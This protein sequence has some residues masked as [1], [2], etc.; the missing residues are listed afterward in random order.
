MT[1]GLDKGAG[2]KSY[3]RVDELL[4]SRVVEGEEAAAG[5][6]PVQRCSRLCTRR[7]RPRQRAGAGD[8][9]AGRIR[10]AVEVDAREAV[11]RKP[12]VAWG[13]TVT[14][15]AFCGTYCYVAEGGSTNMCISRFAAAGA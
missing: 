14:S 5:G 10:V 8:R 7:T 4:S 15:S 3:A 12:K 11:R 13:F 2:A 1:A 6:R 9:W